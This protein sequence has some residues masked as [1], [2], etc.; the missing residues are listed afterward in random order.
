[1]PIRSKVFHRD[2]DSLFWRR[3]P[4]GQC[5]QLIKR[6]PREQ[7]SRYVG[8]KS[9]RNLLFLSDR[10][11]GPYCSFVLFAK[12]GFI[13][14]PADLIDIVKDQL[15]G[16][17]YVKDEDP[18]TF[19]SEKTSRGPLGETW[20]EDSCK[21]SEAIMCAYKLCTVEFKY[22]GMQ[23]KIERFIHDTGLFLSSSRH[24]FISL[25]DLTRGILNVTLCHTIHLALQHFDVLC[26]VLIDR[27]GPGKT[28]GS[29]WQWLIFEN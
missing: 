4:S 6:R 24:A 23:T 15:Y 27:L 28:S 14:L 22:W 16:S 7:I 12:I 8:I 19:V 21:S 1:M 2:R 26:F 5:F 29:V 18:T 11:F 17:D 25:Q 9:T 13:F 20:I 10:F 3:G